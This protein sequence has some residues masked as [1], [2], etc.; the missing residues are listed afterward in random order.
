MPVRVCSIVFVLT[1]AAASAAFAQTPP[2]APPQTPAAPP[3]PPPPPPS[4]WKTTFGAGLTLTSGNSNTSTFNASYNVQYDA[5]TR[6]VF[7]SDGLFIRGTSEGESSA[8]RVGF[9]ARDQYQVNHHAY[10]FGQVQYLHDEFKDIEYL[11]APT[12]GFGYNVIDVPQKTL[13]AVDLGVGGVW[14]KDTNLD[15]R[16]S[17]AITLGERFSQTITHSSTLTQGLT[18]LWPTSDFG[19]YLLTLNAGISASV[20]SRTQLKLEWLDTYKNIP[21]VEGIKK[22]DVSVVIALVFKT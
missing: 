11:V 17:G 21:A 16:P 1:V 22:N 10:I 15:V 2:A 18:G 7:K 8:N 3:A 14:E 6:N 12:S 13:L 9:T 4:P 19:D 20:S 5:K